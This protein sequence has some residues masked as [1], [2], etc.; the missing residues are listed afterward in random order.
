MRSGLADPRGP[1]RPSLAD[2]SDHPQPAAGIPGE[3]AAGHTLGV[4]EIDDIVAVMLARRVCLI[5]VLWGVGVRAAGSPVT[6]EAIWLMRRV[7][8]PVPSPDGK[9][10]VFPVTEPAY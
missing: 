6:H 4:A 3:Y 8:A 2:R 5:A 9:W 1:A 10:V 7:G